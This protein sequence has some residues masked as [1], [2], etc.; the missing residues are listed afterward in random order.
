MVSTPH[1][2]M[3][4]MNGNWLSPWR[5]ASVHHQKAAGGRQ[6]ASNDDDQAP[7]NRCELLR[8]LLDNPMDQTGGFRL[9]SYHVGVIPNGSSPTL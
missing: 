5:T 2:S 1:P 9:A 3:S 8:K 6:S 4:R 7:N